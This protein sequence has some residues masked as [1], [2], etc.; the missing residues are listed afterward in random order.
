MSVEIVRSDDSQAALCMFKN[1]LNLSV[2]D[3]REPL[4]KVVDAG[5]GL[6]VF[7]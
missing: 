5:T 7:E 6:E 4:E 1:G 2:C 3:A